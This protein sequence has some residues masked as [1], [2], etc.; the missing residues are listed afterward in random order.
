M[1]IGSVRRRSNTAVTLAALDDVAADP[2]VAGVK[3]AGTGAVGMVA[4]TAVVVLVDRTFEDVG[5]PSSAP[6]SARR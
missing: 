5:G 6:S 1:K 3:L 4:V 2:T